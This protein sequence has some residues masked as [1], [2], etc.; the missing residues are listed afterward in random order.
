M[1]YIC[2]NC[3]AEVHAE[4]FDEIVE[5]GKLCI[6]CRQKRRYHATLFKSIVYVVKYECTSCG[7][8]RDDKKERCKCGRIR[9]KK[10]VQN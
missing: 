1:K 7:T 4:T 3:N 8:L 2:K 6:V 5:N 10:V 9:S